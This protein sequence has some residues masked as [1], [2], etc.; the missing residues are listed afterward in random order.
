L[1]RRKEL[2]DTL[3]FMITADHVEPIFL[4]SG[5]DAYITKPLNLR[6]FGQTLEDYLRW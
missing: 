6:L 5:G 3:I 4:W 2:R 1:C